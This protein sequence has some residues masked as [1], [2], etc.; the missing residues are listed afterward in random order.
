MKKLL[1]KPMK[2][3]D[4]VL[5]RTDKL[6]PP[7]SLRLKVGP[8]GFYVLFKAT[9][10][11]FF[12]CLKKLCGLKSSHSVLDI[13]C[14]CGLMAIHL[15]KFLNLNGRY[16][17]FD[18]SKPFIDCCKTNISSWY[19]N[20]RFQHVDLY[21]ADYN[22]QGEM[23]ASDWRFPYS[24]NSFDVVFAK[25]VFTHL[26]PA[27]MENYLQETARVLKKGGKCLITFFLI[28]DR[29]AGL[30]KV[31]KYNFNFDHDYG[32]FLTSDPNVPEKAICYDEKFVL[33]RLERNRLRLIEPV[34]Y[35]VWRHRFTRFP[36]CQDMIVV[37]K[38]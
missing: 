2:W 8:F 27:D 15:A 38:D 18:I 22:P 7:K 34:R 3:V 1:L 12:S 13:G 6:A 9:G 29:S 26:L 35:G 31:A 23:K 11:Y 36:N 25:S 28:A 30:P 4:S 33:D 21:N 19:P 37:S 5:E 20:F 17:G 16:E 24:D 14:G 10:R 32:S